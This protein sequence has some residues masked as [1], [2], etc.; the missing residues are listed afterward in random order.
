[1]AG[2]DSLVAEHHTEG[3]CY[4][5]SMP[6]SPREALEAA[7]R[8]PQMVDVSTIAN[9]KVDLRYGSKQN[10]LGRDIYGGFQR[11]LLHKIAAGKF[12]IAARLLAESR[13]DLKFLIFDSLRPH[14]AQIE[15]WNL[16]KGT[17]QQPF[18]ADPAT[19]SL[20]SYGFAIDLGLADSTGRELDM[21]TGFDDLTELA[22]PRSEDEFLA[23]GKLSPLQVSNRKILRAVMEGAGFLQLP[24]EWWHYDALPAAEVRAGYPRCE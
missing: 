6:N 1:V 23:S 18:F 24:H 5:S 8:D 12:V 11:A 15:F 20:H 9:V 4:S 10:L 14:S 17:P 21:G 16:V 19:G 13:F 22:G 7:L 3:L 2:S